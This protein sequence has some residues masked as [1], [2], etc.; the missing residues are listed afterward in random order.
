MRISKAL[1]QAVYRQ[2]PGKRSGGQVKE[3]KKLA[4]AL[5]A[6]PKQRNVGMEL[7]KAA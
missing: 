1:V 4:G 5:K 7:K 2:Q 3:G 6:I